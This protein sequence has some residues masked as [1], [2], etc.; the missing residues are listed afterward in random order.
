[1]VSLVPEPEAPDAEP[2]SGG[3]HHALRALGERNFALFW[4]GGFLASFGGWFQNLA[5]PY[6]LFVSTQSAAW[7]GLATMAQF[8]PGMLMGPWGGMIAERYDL[9]RALLFTQ[10]ARAGVALALFGAWAAGWRE[11]WLLLMLAFLAGVAQGVQMPSWQSFIY[12]LVPRH[13][14]SSAIT[15]NSAQFILARSFGPAVGGV[16]LVWGGPSAAFLTAA[17][18]ILAALAAL[19]LIRPAARTPTTQGGRRGGRILQDFGEALRYLPT[20]PGLVVASCMVLTLSMLGMPVFQQ[21]IVF[22][23]AVFH[24]GSGG[25]ALLNLALGLGTVIGTPLV[26]ALDHRLGRARMARWSLPACALALAGFALA[27]SLA[28]AGASLVVF[29]IAFLAAHTAAQNSVQIVVTDRLRG[30]VL[31]VNV[32]LAGGGTALGSYL[33][34]VLVDLAGP[35]A[36]VLG[37]AALMLGMALALGLRRGPFALGRLDDPHDA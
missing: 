1:M 22:S 19:G 16:I 26:A 20:Q 18:A 4:G 23:E 32:M 7:A 9:R 11:P 35:R 27:P 37:V 5:I 15:L 6:V 12:H 8:L 17:L 34:G 28:A 33:Q 3:V 30:R 2:A 21:V 36:A 14:L 29:G 13:R 31:A 25:L 10:L 24:A